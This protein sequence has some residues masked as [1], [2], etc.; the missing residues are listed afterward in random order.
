MNTSIVN[1]QA[2]DAEIALIRHDGLR[3]LVQNV[4]AAAPRCFWTMPASTTGGPLKT[5]I[6]TRPDSMK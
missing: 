4:L 3:T 1:H 5:Q 6:K 2:L